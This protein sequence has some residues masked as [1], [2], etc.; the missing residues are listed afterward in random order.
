MLVAKSTAATLRQSVHHMK[1]AQNQCHYQYSAKHSMGE[2]VAF[3]HCNQHWCV[4]L[5]PLRGRNVGLLTRCT[6]HVFVAAGH[7]M[8]PHRSDHDYWSTDKLGVVSSESHSGT[9]FR[10]KSRQGLKTRPTELPEPHM[11]LCRKISHAVILT[12][13]KFSCFCKRT[14]LV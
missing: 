5:C 13:L 1:T 7:R 8:T 9:L 11:C 2:R 3:K 12:L 14:R 10:L 4:F 6:S